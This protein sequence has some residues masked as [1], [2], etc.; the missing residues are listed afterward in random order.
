MLFPLSSFMDGLVRSFPLACT[1]APIYGNRTGLFHDFH[2]IVGPLTDPKDSS[3]PAFHVV[4]P[5]LPGYAWSTLPRKSNF[6]IDDIG[7][8]YNKL[9]VEVLG[10]QQYVAQG[11]DWVNS[12]IH[13]EDPFVPPD[14]CS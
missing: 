3:K 5:S 7:R 4:I 13:P 10:Y 1:L 9:M 11:G 8:I 6:Q 2:K 14:L 12:Q